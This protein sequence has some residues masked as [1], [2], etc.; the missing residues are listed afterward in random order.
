MKQQENIEILE[1]LITSVKN[2]GYKNTLNLL[3][4][5]HK[6]TI[7]TN[8]YDLFIINLVCEHFKI[9]QDDLFYSRYVHGDRKYAIGFCV[10]YLYEKK[11]LG[12]IAKYIF[13]NKNKALLNRYRQMI[14]D[15]NKKDLPYFEIKQELDKKVE[16]YK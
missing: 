15:L 4:E 6:E 9:T 13:N 1:H 3:K 5:N 16:N 2:R 7:I 12:E 11:T 10:H 14:I 8:E